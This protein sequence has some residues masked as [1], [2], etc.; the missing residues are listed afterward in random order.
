VRC[1]WQNA[2]QSSGRPLLVVPDGCID[3]IW[4]GRAIVIAGPDTGPVLEMVAPDATIVGIRFR[5]GAAVPWLRVPA[6]EIANRRLS[7]RELWGRRAHRLAEQ[8]FDAADSDAAAATLERAVLA[9]RPESERS[10]D[11][12]PILRRALQRHLRTEAADLREVAAELGMSERTIRR[13]CDELFGYGPK[14]F[15]RIQ[16]FQRFLACVRRADG[17]SLSALASLCGYADQ[18]HLSREVRRL[19]GLTPAAIVG[20]LGQR[21]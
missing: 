3:L 9:S 12:A 7:L 19:S 6:A 13:R 2:L 16:R 11:S 21:L 10:H 1:V 17:L 4:T 5:P 18:A 14:T 8:L 15:V 20:Q